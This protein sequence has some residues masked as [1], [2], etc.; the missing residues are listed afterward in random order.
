MIRIVTWDNIGNTLLGMRAWDSWDEKTQRRLLAEDPDGRPRV[1]TP[2]EALGG[3]PYELVWLYDPIKSGRG[4]QGLHEEFGARTVDTNDP[5]AV[6]REVSAAD[7][8]IL[9]KETLAPEIL[10]SAPNVRLV[11]HLGLDIRGVPLEAARARGIPVAA[12]PLVNYSAVAEHVWTFILAD[13]KRLFDQREH[14]RSGDYVNAWGGF[15]PGIGIVSDLTLG[16]LGMGEIARWVA[17]VAQA[18]GMRTVYWDIQRFPELEA[19]YGMEYVEWDDLFRQADVVSTQLA[20]NE[21]TEGIIGAR[22]F[23]LM[24]PTSLFINTARGKLV[25]EA[26][27]ARALETNT[28]R[29][30]AIDAFAEEPLPLDSPLHALNNLPE[31]RVILTPHSAIRRTCGSTSAG[32]CAASRCNTSCRDPAVRLQGQSRIGPLSQGMPHDRH[33]F[34]LLPAHLR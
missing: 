9:H 4:F 27:L 11:Q 18:F 7:F 14:M 15:H 29:A 24:K 2:G 8:V 25:D 1:M 5:D 6:A 19:Q 34:R 20:L 13:T 33:S 3:E 16:L 22:E 21:N 26:A 17:R 12:T 23:G 31:Q 30:A 32:H 10:Q 28:I